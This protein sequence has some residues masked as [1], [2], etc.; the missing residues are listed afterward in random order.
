M[1]PASMLQGIKKP[2]LMT[3]EAIAENFKILI[4][5]FFRDIL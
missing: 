5:D 1:N 4:V 2:L 3:E